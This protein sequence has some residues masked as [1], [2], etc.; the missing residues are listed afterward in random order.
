M[1]GGKGTPER[2][3][4]SD[5]SPGSQPTPKKF[6]YFSLE[7]RKTARASS[8]KTSPSGVAATEAQVTTCNDAKDKSKLKETENTGDA[9]ATT[10]G[11]TGSSSGSSEPRSEPPSRKDSISSVTFRAPRNPSLPQGLKKPHGGSRIR[12]A[13]PPHRRRSSL[14]IVILGSES[15]YLLL[16][17]THLHL[18]DVPPSQ[19]PHPDHQLL[20]IVSL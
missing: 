18:T 4:G 9:S 20:P 1:S 5:V 10:P 16:L 14:G 6:D 3:P 19:F 17:L 11:E 7:R 2:T 15:R 12:E 8:A 13:S